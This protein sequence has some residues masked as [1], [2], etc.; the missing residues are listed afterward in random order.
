MLYFITRT[1]VR[2]KYRFLNAY[3]REFSEYLEG[4]FVRAHLAF[5]CTG[6]EEKPILWDKK[7]VQA[8]SD[9]NEETVNAAFHKMEKYGQA[10]VTP[11][12]ISS[13]GERPDESMNTMME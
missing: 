11:Y 4:E 5:L 7:E 12:Q 3:A 10:L 13:I 1:Y 8:F 9:P 6:R 2:F